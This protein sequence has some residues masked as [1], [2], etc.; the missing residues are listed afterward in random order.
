MSLYSRQ[1]YFKIG[2]VFKVK[3]LFVVVDMQYDFIDGA[4]GSPHARQIVPYVIS[5]VKAAR[6]RCA[7]VVFTK[8]THETNYLSTQEGKYLPI[9]HCIRGTHGWD[10]LSEVFLRGA[11]IFEKSTFGSV[12]LAE[13]A[14]AGQFKTITFCGVCTDI[15]V[16]S[17]ALL[18]KSYCPEAKIVVLPSA[19]AGTNEENHLAALKT[20]RN[21]Q[22]NV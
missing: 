8:D 12:G 11:R 15:C 22:I 14:K 17:N 4:L 3:E 21:C 10:I 7:E 19:C 18:L 9:A 20:M 16:V 13:Y 6:G 1:N 5:A 2:E